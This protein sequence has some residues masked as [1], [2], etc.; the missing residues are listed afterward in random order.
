MS[1][2]GDELFFAGKNLEEAVQVMEYDPDEARDIL[3]ATVEYL[4]EEDHRALRN[5][6]GNIQR[7]YEKLRELSALLGYKL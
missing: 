5:Y 6:Q 7:Q 3:R 4:G 1:D 2:P